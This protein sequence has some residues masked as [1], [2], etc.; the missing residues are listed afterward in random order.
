MMKKNKP[1]FNVPNLGFFKSVKAR[2][3]RPRGTHNKKRM[4][5][6]FMGALPKVGYRN[7]PAM[8]NL[9]SSGAKEVLVNNT[10]ELGNIKEK[11]VVV[12]IAAGVGGRKRKL[13]AEKAKTMS[14]RILNMADNGS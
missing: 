10:A 3:R 4:K 1:K 6:A 14:L 7:P 13:I 8:R 12:R 11:G 2:W 9:H 5:C